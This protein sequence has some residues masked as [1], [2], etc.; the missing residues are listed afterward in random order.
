MRVELINTGSELLLGFT[1]NTH[2]AYIARQLADIGLRLNRQ[3][4]VA[5]DRAEM[6][7][8]VAEALARADVLIITGGLGPTSDDFTR[9][10]VAELLGRKLVCDDA[11]AVGI[12]ERFRK[13]GIRMPESVNVQAM[14][15]VGAQ[16][17]PNPN[18][19]AP[20]LAIDQAASLC[21]YCQARRANSNRC[22]SNTSCRCSNR[23]SSARPCSIAGCSKLWASQNQ[24]W[25]RRWRLY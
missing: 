1:T 14:V 3:T 8:A 5:D 25:R 21:F 9:E 13:R 7:R 6:R 2:L 23:I 22:S 18:G 11:I 16:I 17:L 24:S 4:T 20:G 12:A 19:T 10:V 15:P